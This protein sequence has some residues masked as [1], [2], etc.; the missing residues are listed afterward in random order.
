M[1]IFG[2]TKIPEIK[3]MA[4]NKEFKKASHFLNSV[5]PDKTVKKKINGGKTKARR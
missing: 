3:K 1:N 4:M 2:K 5:F